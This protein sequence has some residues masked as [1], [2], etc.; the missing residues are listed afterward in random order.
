MHVLLDPQEIQAVVDAKGAPVVFNL[1]GNAH[2]GNGKLV[3][4]FSG[5]VTFEYVEGIAD[6]LFDFLKPQS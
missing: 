3:A 5:T 1:K 6:Q 2:D 4:I